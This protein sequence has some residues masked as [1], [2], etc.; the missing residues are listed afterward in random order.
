MSQETG[1]TVDIMSLALL[2]LL[3]GAAAPPA[4]TPAPNDEIVVMAHKLDGWSGRFEI[5]G[6]RRKCSTKTSTGDPDIDAV[7]CQAFLT[8]ADQ[9]QS[10]TDASDERGIDPTTRRARKESLIAHMRD[11]ISDRRIVLLAKLHE[12]RAAQTAH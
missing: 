6:V 8:C 5:R 10:E 11:C 4:A 1:H 9:F 3:I 12:R 2:S 7:G